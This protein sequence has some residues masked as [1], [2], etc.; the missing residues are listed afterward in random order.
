MEDGVQLAWGPD[1]GQERPTWCGRQHR[2][3]EQRGRSYWPQYL[4]GGLCPPD[5][6]QDGIRTDAPPG[7]R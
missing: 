5:P 1:G 7:G 2:A 6:G 4:P 3:G